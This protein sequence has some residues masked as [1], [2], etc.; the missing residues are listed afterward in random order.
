MPFL[1]HFNTAGLSLKSSSKA[2][3]VSTTA[4]LQPRLNKLLLLTSGFLIASAKGCA[5]SDSK[6]EGEEGRVNGEVKEWSSCVIERSLFLLGE[7]KCTYW[8][9]LRID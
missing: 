7:S 8:W 9:K 4:A 3:L 6:S 2:R 5:K 1:F